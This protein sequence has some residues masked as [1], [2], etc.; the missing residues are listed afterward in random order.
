MEIPSLVRGAVARLPLIGRAS[1]SRPQAAAWRL[2]PGGDDDLAARMVERS[3][4][5]MGTGEVGD[6]TDAPSTDALKDALAEARPDRSATATARAAGSWTAFRS[7]I[8]A[9]DVVVVVRGGRRVSVAE[10]V[11]DYEYRSEERDVRLR[12]VRPVRWL[13]T[14]LREDQLPDDVRRSLRAPGTLGRV[15]PP[16]A[17]ARLRAAA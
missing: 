13:S 4:V 1:T 15:T 14:D 5:A 17:A 2:R 12:H 3:V 11:G 16:D 6:L 7:G 8:A 9:G 10:V